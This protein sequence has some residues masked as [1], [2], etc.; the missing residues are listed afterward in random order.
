MALLGVAG[1]IGLIR[2]REYQLKK[3]QKRLEAEVEKRTLT[4]QQQAEELKALDKAKTRFFSNITHEFRTPL[5]L[6]I[7]PLEQ[8]IEE[9]PPPTI[10]R[11]RMNSVLK[12]ARHLLIL[13]N[14]LL[15]LSKIESGHMQMEVTRGDII[16]HT[17]ELTR[18][19]H[20]LAQKKEQ[21]LTFVAGS[22]SWEIHFDKRKWDKILYNLLSNAVKFTEKGG[23]I[24]VNLLSFQKGKQEYIWLGVKDTGIGIKQEQLPKVFNRFYQTDSSSTRTQD[25][26]GI[27]LALVKELLEMQGGEIWVTSELNKGTTFEVHLP[28]L[29]AT[30]AQ[31]LAHETSSDWDL[32][33]MTETPS[34][35]VPAFPNANGSTHQ[36]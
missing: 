27:G 29:E 20:P 22:Q 15:D 7:G 25:G 5:S 3:D 1:I 4:V 18:R 12:N 10:F 14:Q 17:Q 36:N 31:P 6:I 24:Q 35:N 21:R 8:V 33:K 30:E 26:T 16:A 11:R 28:V 9:P 19:F 13:I 34:P 2:A 32:L 23:G